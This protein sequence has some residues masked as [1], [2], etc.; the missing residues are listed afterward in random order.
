MP[1]L[2]SSILALVAALGL[3]SG[4][5][6][7]QRG[8]ASPRDTAGGDD[9]HGADTATDPCAGVVCDDGD[10]CTSDRCDPET[11]LCE[12]LEVSYAPAFRV[13]SC[14]RDADCDDGDPCT[15]DRC[16]AVDDACT[17]ADY[18]MCESTPTPG[19]GGCQL[20]GCPSEDPCQV[21]ECRPD[22]SCAWR[23]APACV[24]D[25]GAAG[26]LTLDAAR[27]GRGAGAFA[28][29]AGRVRADVDAVCDTLSC[30]CAATPALTDASQ[31]QLLLRGP[32]TDQEIGWTC[33]TDLC[34]AEQTTTCA[35][36]HHDAAY[37]V[38]GTLTASSDRP[39]SAGAPQEAPDPDPAPPLPE[40]DGLLVDDYC[41]QTTPAGLPGRY[42]GSLETGAISAQVT[43][44]GVVTRDADGGLTLSLSERDCL[45]CARTGASPYFP[46]TVTL[47]PGDGWVSLELAVPNWCGDN[48]P[49]A[50]AV[51]ASHRNTLSGEYH[52]AWAAPQRFGAAIAL[53][54]QGTL[55]LTRLP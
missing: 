28:K 48:T 8:Q 42:V 10:P 7:A 13:P 37:W 26:A 34:G 16:V 15:A 54:S 52:D 43:L 3:T 50:V 2:L 24:A 1:T 30:S 17:G 5:L 11:G 44:E 46:Q 29:V 18:R 49:P 40:A 41:L 9:A 19:C 20:A 55:T 32:L 38:W 14:E 21:G 31:E 45:G 12:H 22:G 25:C 39:M 47:T 27:Y 36:A 53:C 23:V 6:E 51:L 33:E 35:P 4:C